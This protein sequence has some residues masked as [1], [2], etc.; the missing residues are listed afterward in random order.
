MSK[1]RSAALS[2]VE[3]ESLLRSD[4]EQSL[5]DSDS[6]IEDEVEDHALLDAEGR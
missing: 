2:D 1:K 4:S 6:D 5:T 3:V